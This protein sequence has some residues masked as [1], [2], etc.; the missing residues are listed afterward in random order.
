MRFSI[1]IPNF[2]YEQFV[3]RTIRSALD[4]TY[5]ELEVL[6]SDNASTD[7]SVEVIRTIDDRRLRLRVNRCNVGFAGNLDCA[8]RDAA[9]D[10]FIMLSSDDVMR[11]TALEMYAK[12][13]NLLGSKAAGTVIC[14]SV[15][16]IDAED[17]VTGRHDLPRHQVWRE[18][19][20]AADLEA[21]LGCPVYRTPANE[22]LSRCLG[23]MQNPFFFCATAYPRQLY[24]AVGGYGGGRFVAPD[25]WFHWRL[26][27]AAEEAVFIKTPLF[28]Y[29]WHPHNQTAQQSQ[30]GALKY[31][32]DEYAATFELDAAT[33]QRLGISRG[34]L[35]RTFVEHDIVRHGLG[36]LAQGK[37]RQAQR[38]LRFGQGVYPHH[39]RRNWHAW[40]F[41]SLL[42]LG[43]VGSYLAARLRRLNAE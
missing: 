3:E 9:G 20:R 29:R 12:T 40:G 14:S 7:R 25:K 6:V 39:V 5:G 26:L 37:R 22:L 43:P 16:L 10:V 8:A 17:R 30:S 15:D 38:T 11:P 35:E 13:F 36:L 41:R 28:G 27:A 18:S 31:L 23:S 33:L 1:C 19:D 34:D 32:V 42:A 24:E 2:N 4:Q 21:A